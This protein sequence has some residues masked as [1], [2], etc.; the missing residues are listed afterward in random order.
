MKMRQLDIFQKYS[1]KTQA[2]HRGQEGFKE[3]AKRMLEICL[4]DLGGG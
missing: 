2:K 1:G 4:K 3:I